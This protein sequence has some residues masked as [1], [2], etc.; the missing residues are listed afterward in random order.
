MTVEAEPPAWPAETDRAELPR[1]GIDPVSIDPQLISE[2]GGI[3]V[4][5]AARWV[6]AQ[7][8]GYLAGDLLD[9]V[10]VKLHY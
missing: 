8:V 3:D 5:T 6:G 9:V 2:C 7:Q 1:M 10:G 4:A